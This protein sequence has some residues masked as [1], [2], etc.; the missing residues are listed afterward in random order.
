MALRAVLFCALALVLAELSSA[1]ADGGGKHLD[2]MIG[3]PE[4]ADSLPSDVFAPLENR[5]AEGGQV[6]EADSSLPEGM[7]MPE[8]ER[9][10][11]S[12]G[13]APSPSTGDSSPDNDDELMKKEALASLE[14]A[15][16]Y[17]QR[18]RVIET[19]EE[20]KASLYSANGELAWCVTFLLEL[21]YNETLDKLGNAKRSLAQCSSALSMDN[22]GDATRPLLYLVQKALSQIDE[23]KITVSGLT[24]PPSEFPS[25]ESVEFEG[26]GVR[27]SCKVDG[28]TC[29]FSNCGKGKK[30]PKCAIG[31][32]GSVTGGARGTMYTVTSSDDNPSRPQGGTFRYGAQLANG[33]NGGVWITFARSMTIVLRDMVWIRSSTTVDGRGV[34]VVFTNKCFVLG[35][36]SNV[37]L[38]NFE[39]SRV[40]QTD[41][42]HIFGS[43]RGVWVDHITSSDAKLGLV[44]VV[45]GSTDVT[46]SNCY[47][48]NKNFNMLLGASDADSQDRNMRVTIFRNWFRDSMQRMPHCRWGYCHVVNN[49][50]TNWGYYAIGGRANAQILSESNAF[51][52]GRRREVTPW[53]PG[54][55]KALDQS[56]TIQSRNDLY[57]GGSTF[58]QFVL[59]GKNSQHPKYVTPRHAPPVVTPNRLTKMIQACAGA[60]YGQKL[61]RCLYSS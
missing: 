49:L 30:L 18:A 8:S 22:S 24:P 32:A 19:T 47:L 45:Q 2:D 38:H 57:L 20:C 41:T 31:Y 13:G 35:G 40:P 33:R 28:T 60:L 17:L 21:K 53:F 44:S 58:H 12:P 39:I 11:P 42:I 51:I 6:E 36:V 37:I 54:A 25:T 5:L 61:Q 59:L 15:Q 26:V 29:Q 3:Q 23:A 56:S 16:L 34:N 4:G 1:Q 7:T 55:S 46:I 43:S 48:S 27:D 14:E 10:Q 9:L 50:Y 52:P